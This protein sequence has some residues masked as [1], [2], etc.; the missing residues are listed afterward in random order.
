M[1]TVSKSA[2]DLIQ[3]I[4]QPDNKRI[5]LQDIFNDPW[6]MK[7]TAKN[8]LKLTFSKLSNF[9]KFSKVHFS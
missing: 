2:K 9:T 7:E 3:R 5:S 4:L 1:K 6:V 8:P